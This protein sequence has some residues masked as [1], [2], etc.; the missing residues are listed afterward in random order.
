MDAPGLL[1]RLDHCKNYL[2]IGQNRNKEAFNELLST[3]IFMTMILVIN[4]PAIELAHNH[5]FEGVNP[6]QKKTTYGFVNSLWPKCKV[7][8]GLSS[9]NGINRL[10]LAMISNSGEC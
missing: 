7:E 8:Q 10:F 5:G 4:S 1:I 2:Q 3:P 9:V 6:D